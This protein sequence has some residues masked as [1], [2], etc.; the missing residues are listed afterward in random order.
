MDPAA[1]VQVQDA[2]PARRRG[3]G[4]GETVA[5]GRMTEAVA[6]L[7]SPPK[8]PLME[9]GLGLHQPLP[10]IVWACPAQRWPVLGM[11]LPWFNRSYVKFFLLTSV[12]KTI[13]Q[14]S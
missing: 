9:T 1:L 5:S 3:E 11:G 2:T 13:T 12:F 14:I 6:P 7:A 4:P 8:L 10:R